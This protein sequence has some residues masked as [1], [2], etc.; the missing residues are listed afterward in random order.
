[1]HMK[2]FWTTSIVLLGL[3]VS[4][5]SATAGPCSNE[6]AQFETAVQQS[7]KTPYAGP[8]VTE[9]TGAK[10]GHQPTPSSVG[11]AEQQAQSRFADVMARVKALDAQG[12][13]AA[14]MQALTAAKRMFDFQ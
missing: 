7:A 12:D 9:T 11:Q 4:C 14:C 1:M 6:I 10:L 8:T 2:Q 5:G 3:A 13:R